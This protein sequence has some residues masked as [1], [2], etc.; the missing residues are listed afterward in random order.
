MAVIGMI[1]IVFFLKDVSGKKKKNA[2]TEDGR[3]TSQIL[4]DACAY[5]KKE[6]R[7]LMAYLGNVVS[8]STFFLTNLFGSN[9]YYQ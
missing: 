1:P 8:M 3:N 5:L 9:I 4:K 7:L 6:R 2:T